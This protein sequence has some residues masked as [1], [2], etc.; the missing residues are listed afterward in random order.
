MGILTHPHNWV[1]RMSDL[2]AEGPGLCSHG[3][4]SLW[5]KMSFT[6]VSSGDVESCWYRNWFLW[7]KLITVETEVNPTWTSGEI[8]K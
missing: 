4:H 3:S 8:L 1:D 2:H 7:Y 6:S 5:Q